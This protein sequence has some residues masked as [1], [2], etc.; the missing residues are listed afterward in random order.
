MLNILKFLWPQLPCF[1]MESLKA[2]ILRADANGSTAIPA[3]IALLR[4]LQEDLQE[5]VDSLLRT[6]DLINKRMWSAI[7][8]PME[9]LIKP[10]P[11]SYARGSLEEVHLVV[12]PAYNAIST[13]DEEV[14][15]RIIEKWVATRK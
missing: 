10:R 15:G 2:R 5:Q 9:F 1:S 14:Y 12:G 6:G 7:V 13:A 8:D 3:L 11:S 4:K